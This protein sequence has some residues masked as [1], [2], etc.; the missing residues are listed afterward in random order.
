MHRLRCPQANEDL[1]MRVEQLYAPDGQL[2][3]LWTS[4]LEA[5]GMAGEHGRRRE[6]AGCRPRWAAWRQ[7]S[8]RA[9]TDRASR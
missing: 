7:A 1:L 6:P 4:A 8:W 9:P 3:A 5:R 2:H